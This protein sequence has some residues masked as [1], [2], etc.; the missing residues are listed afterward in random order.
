MKIYLVWLF[1]KYINHKQ[2]ITIQDDTVFDY[3]YKFNTLLQKNLLEGN[4]KFKHNDIL[5]EYSKLHTPNMQQDLW[6]VSITSSQGAK[7]TILFYPANEK[8]IYNIRIQHI[9][10]Q[11]KVLLNQPLNDITQPIVAQ[12]ATKPKT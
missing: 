6:Y 3:I 2:T 9:S 11:T 10:D 1:N 4:G 8:G 7:K 5:Y 12:N